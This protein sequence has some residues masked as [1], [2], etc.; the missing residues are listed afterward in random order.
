[1]RFACGVFI[2]LPFICQVFCHL[3]G[4]LDAGGSFRLRPC[5]IPPFC[6][7][8]NRARSGFR[9]SVFLAGGRRFAVFQR[10][11]NAR[12]AS[13][14]VRR[15]IVHLRNISLF[16]KLNSCANWAPSGTSV[17]ANYR[18]AHRAKSKPDFISKMGTAILNGELRM[19]NA[20]YGHA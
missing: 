7:S 10:D 15:F 11:E 9:A 18:A 6:G 3:H 1:M 4:P 5:C 19:K 12:D 14:G 2:I 8:L 16:L 20:E 13:F 17:G